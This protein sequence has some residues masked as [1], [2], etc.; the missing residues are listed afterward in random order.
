MIKTIFWVLVFLLNA[1][2][3]AIANIV[4]NP[5]FT[6][7][8]DWTQKTANKFVTNLYDASVSKFND[9]TGSMKL[10]HS[11]RN[12]TNDRIASD[13]V[14]VQ[15]GLQYTASFSM[16]STVSNSVA[17]F[18][19]SHYDI[20]HNFIRNDTVSKKFTY[21]NANIWQKNSLS[22]AIPSD[23]Y[24]VKLE[25]QNFI[26]INQTNKTIWIDN[27]SLNLKSSTTD[28]SIVNNVPPTQPI[29]RNNL[30][31][32]SNFKNGTNWIQTSLNSTVNTLFDSS[33]SKDNDGSGSIK[34]VYSGDT[35]TDDRLRASPLIAV[36]PNTEYEVGFSMRS[37]SYPGPNVYF[38]I[39]HFDK[40]KKRLYTDP[41][42]GRHSNSNKLLWEDTFTTIKTSSETAYILLQIWNY[43]AVEGID[44]TVWIDNV[45][46]YE[47]FYR[48]IQ[49]KNSF[50]GAWTKVDSYG[51][52]KIVKD[53]KTIPF[54]PLCVSNDNYRD[55]NV[56]SKQ[57]FNCIAWA[58]DSNTALKAANA[59]SNFN[60]DGMMSGIDITRFMIPG[61]VDYENLN[62]L[63][64]V[65]NGLKNNGLENHILWYYWD[66][67]NMY[68]EW[69]IPKKVITQ[70]KNIDKDHPMLS[71]NGN[72]GMSRKYNGLI[73]LTST[74]VVNSRE[75]IANTMSGT[76][77]FR[78]LHY[79]EGQTSIPA[80]AQINLGISLEK[81]LG[82]RMRAYVYKSL[83]QGAKAIS[84]W[85]DRSPNNPIYT[86]DEGDITKQIWWNDFPNIRRE[87]DKLMKYGII[88]AVNWT[89]WKARNSTPRVYI[90]TKEVNGNKYILVS[91]L[92]SSTKLITIELENLSSEYSKISD[93]FSSNTI[94]N[95]NN[96]IFTLQINGYGSR[97]IEL[98]K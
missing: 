52:F 15:S 75:S 92:N 48:S 94:T 74:Y 67:E 53:G 66:N 19:I 60:P 33:V 5:T 43:K 14:S 68:T 97:V 57:G 41:T 63:K 34:L 72:Y 49:P 88:Q 65:I 90:G 87:I 70:I 59:K 95:I 7:Y 8:T 80:V 36:K 55:L 17:F 22:F 6:G 77:N 42:Q 25:V 58:Q 78:N 89:D 27:V 20:N 3:T 2:A 18:L 26:N 84:Y 73:D 31:P 83:I 38:I 21:T 30:V 69:N 85:R 61:H 51:N 93:F 28:D 10:T 13:F 35:A 71:L 54:F 64:N 81:G 32:N 4:N 76:E 44:R 12:D 82:P 23:T 1:D 16:K 45:Y 50:E 24:Y 91:N 11:G 37:N 96:S 47:G 98:K 29:I 62:K 9:Q 40:N 39:V 56:Y 46:M 79:T 86:N